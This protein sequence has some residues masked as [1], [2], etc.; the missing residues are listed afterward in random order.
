MTR[1][2]SDAEEVQ[3]FLLDGIPFLIVNLLKLFG[4][5][6]VM[7]AM[8]PTLS[9]LILVPAPFIILFFRRYLPK[10]DRM[11]S[12]SF[13]YRSAMTARMNDSFTGVR[14]VKALERKKARTHPSRHEAGRSETARRISASDL[15]RFSR[16]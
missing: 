12:K 11:Y 7:I 14:V 9:V 8:R 10:F 4:V 3:W 2:N 5:A 16:S 15:E 1:V 13:R 6:A